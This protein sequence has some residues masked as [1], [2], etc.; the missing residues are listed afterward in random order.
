VLIAIARALTMRPSE[1][2]DATEPTDYEDQ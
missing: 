2:I 1:L